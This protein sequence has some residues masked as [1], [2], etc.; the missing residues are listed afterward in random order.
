MTNLRWFFADG[1]DENPDPVDPLSLWLVRAQCIRTGFPQLRGRGFGPREESVD[2]AVLEFAID[3]AYFFGEALGALRPDLAARVLAADPSSRVALD[4]TS[5]RTSM[6]D[7]EVAE[8]YA[9]PM[10]FATEQR[11]LQPENTWLPWWWLGRPGS[12][13][14]HTVRARMHVMLRRHFAAHVMYRMKIREDFWE[15]AE[16]HRERLPGQALTG[17]F[18]PWDHERLTIWVEETIEAYQRINGAL[19]IVRE[20]DAVG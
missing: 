17:L 8:M 16:R 2:V 20:Q 7:R 13:P 12:T 11:E 10:N 19:P 5:G 18:G 15:R 1:G 14:P 9:A 4:A 3:H 6:S